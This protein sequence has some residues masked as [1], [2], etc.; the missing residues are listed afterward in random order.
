VLGD[1]ANEVVFWAAV[2]GELTPVELPL[3]VGAML[4]LTTDG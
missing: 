1:P 4:K 3:D 2:D